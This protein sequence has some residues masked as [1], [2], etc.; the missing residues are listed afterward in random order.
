MTERALSERELNRA[1]LARQ[2]L[3]ERTSLPLV[4]VVERMGGLQTQYAPSGYLGLWTRMGTFARADLTRALERRRAVTGTLMRVTIHTVSARDYPLLAEGVRMARRDWF[5]RTYGSRAVGIDM[6]KVAERVRGYLADG[7]VRSKELIERLRSDGLPDAAWGGVGLWVDLLRIPP[8]GTWERRSADLYGL[9]E[10]WL[11]PSRVTEAE[12]L[13]H[14]LRRYLGGF[15]PAPIGDVARWAGV[16]VTRLKPVAEGMRLRRFRDEQGGE[17]VDL[18]GAVLP[19]GDAEAPVRFLPVWD[20]MLLA[21]ARRAGVLPEEH[22]SRIFTSVAPQSISTFLVDG[23]VAGSWRH[24]GKR[25]VIEPFGPLSRSVRRELK[26]EAEGL[27][28]LY[29]ESPS[30]LH[31]TQR[32]VQ[33]RASRRSAGMGRPHRSQR[34]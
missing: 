27:E 34:P 2:F 13:R 31:S 28:A 9:A 15:G 30:L 8:S 4:A 26:E 20:A 21:S 29:A 14:L 19:G 16:P 10:T 5:L 33:G 6:D 11:G 23:I 1:M 12:G 3:L 7:P 24:D 25:I 32:E 22:R 18:T 17:L